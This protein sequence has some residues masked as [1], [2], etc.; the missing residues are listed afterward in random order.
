MERE[1]RIQRK[2]ERD[3]KREKT[4][5]WINLIRYRFSTIIA[6]EATSITK[7]FPFPFKILSF[8]WTCSLQQYG[9][10]QFTGNLVLITLK[11]KEIVWSVNWF[12]L[13]FTSFTMWTL[14]WT[15]WYTMDYWNRKLLYLLHFIF[16]F[17]EVSMKVTAIYKDSFFS[18]DRFTLF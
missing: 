7:L 14:T 15:I 18:T 9:H 6:V 4:F 3:R 10:S 8:L 2:I 16:W 1:N 5:H 12:F 13:F 11:G 17:N